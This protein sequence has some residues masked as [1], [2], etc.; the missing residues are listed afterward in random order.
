MSQSSNEDSIIEVQATGS[1]RIMAGIIGNMDPFDDTGEQWA[2]YI[3]RFEHYILANEIRTAKKVPVLFSVMGPTTY[4]LLCS[5][6]APDKPGEMDYGRVVEVLQA[7]FAPRPLVI[8][9]RFRFHKRNQGE[10]ETV[11]QYVAVLKRLSE[12]CEF[13]AYLEDALRDRFVCG[14]K[15]E[16]VQKCLLTEKDLTFQKAVDYAV[17]AETATRDVQQLSSSL[18]VHAISANKGDQCRRCGK[19]NDTDK[20]CWYK[21]RD[22]YQCGRKGHSKHMCKSKARITQA[23]SSQDREW[24]QKGNTMKRSV[25]DRKKRIHHVDARN[26][27]ES[28]E[29]K[30]D[31]GSELG[32]YALSE[33]GKYSRISV[34]PRV[35]GKKMEMELDT[36]AAV[37]LIYWEL[38]KSKLSKLPLQPTEIMLKTYT[39]EPLAPEGVIK[40]Q[41]KLNKQCAV[42]PLYIVKVDAPPRFGRE[43]LRVIKLNWKDL[44]TVHAFEQREKDSL[45]LVLK[46]HSAVF[47]TE[48]GTLKQIKATLTVRPN[49]IP[50]FC[51]PRNVPYALRP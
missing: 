13:G 51:P 24:R 5:L 4:G 30:S 19:M 46:R 28:D 31:T 29:T 39:G 1:R 12:H 37:S 14:L 10:E 45:K 48:L 25:K 18:K 47:S 7:H 33:K 27:S 23:R 35:N 17:S 34:L 36:G 43:W 49:S 9:E 16:T 21:D 32:L 6:V 22:C 2:T 20:D 50:K 40:V 3:E 11:A 15:T 42:L 8:A 44:K 41:V 38:Y 26:V